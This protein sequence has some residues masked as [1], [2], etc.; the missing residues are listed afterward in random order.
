MLA[1]AGDQVS[2]SLFS[3]KPTPD[4]NQ[5]MMENT[6]YMSPFQEGW[7]ATKTSTPTPN[8]QND[9]LPLVKEAVN[10]TCKVPLTNSTVPE[11]SKKIQ[12]PRPVGPIQAA[13]SP[14]KIS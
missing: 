1:V 10:D 14:G 13:T 9:S 11:E 3:S 5:K 8:L 12:T 7:M 6:N 4:G 2:S